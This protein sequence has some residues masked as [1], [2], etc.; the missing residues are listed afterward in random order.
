MSAFHV[1][2]QL[3][4]KNVP[5]EINFMIWSDRMD[6]VALSNVKGEVA[7]HR[8]S[9]TRAWNLSPPKDNLQVNAIA[10]RPDGKVLAV[11]YNSGEVLLISV[12]NKKTLNVKD[13]RTE[14]TCL[15]WVQEKVELKSNDSLNLKE[16]QPKDYMKYIDLT[17]LYL[18]D[19]PMNGSSDSSTPGDTKET[20]FL[21]EQTELNLLLVGTKDGYLHI[22]VFGCFTCSILNINDYL[23]SACSIEDI[24]ISEDLSKIFVTVKDAQ[25]N[26]K[27][28][29]IN[30]QIFK[31]HVQELFC[32]AIK[33]VKLVDLV[34]YLTNTITNIT[35]TWE[36][37][38]LEF[39]HK[40]SKYAKK[41]PEGGI[42]ADFLDFLM[43]GICAP[44]L[45]E[46]LMTDLT[47]KGLEKFGQ[48][49]EMS[50]SNIQKLL[51]NNI[52][53]FGQ[54][55][56]YHLAE[57]RGMARFE[58]RYGI[59]GINEDQINNA[60]Q[61]TGAFLIKAGE[62]QQVINHSVI[63]YKAFFRWLYG[64]ILYLTD[65]AVSSEIH[66]TAEQDLTYI[67]EFLQNFDQIG[68]KGKEG[69]TTNGF[70]ME[71]VGQYLADAPLK[72]TSDLDGNEWQNFLSKNECLR[73]HAHILQHYKSTSLIQQFKELAVNISDIFDTPKM[74]LQSEFKAS[75]VFDFFDFNAEPLKMSS[76]NVTKE[77]MLFSFIEPS[78]NIYLL[79]VHVTDDKCLAR[80]G[81][82][83]FTQ[84]TEDNSQVYDIL[85]IAF[86]SNNILSVLLQENS[87]YKL[88]VLL[89]FS[90]PSA[91]DNLVEI[92]IHSKINRQTLPNSDGSL[93]SP[94]LIK[95]VEMSA[96]RFAVSGARR[97]S[98][99]LSENKRK[100]KLF[101]MEAEEEDE[102]DADMT[103]NTSK[104]E[105]RQD[106]SSNDVSL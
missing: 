66:K 79:Q 3:E 22:R 78:T 71:R 55:L 63:N 15:K 42:T 38:L 27:I 29:V 52:T 36:S 61:S 12:E 98:I 83:H 5:N 47:K 84:S 77:M 45:E 30:A 95:N 10:W 85:D 43:F 106:R 11:G 31:T 103:C 54:N 81:K 49:I 51:L 60:I 70:V 18:K 102:E 44:E 35:E 86:Y 32:I 87:P 16:E 91:L 96:S 8:L 93:I 4:D 19:P 65:E 33:Y 90:L 26:I 40:L 6:L 64:V 59:T 62:M 69:Q 67:T 80:Y 73:N 105:S 100:V 97:V 99:V 34:K 58:H 13:A 21:Q 57:L 41:V 56:S 39:D 14:I 24:H 7:L 75:Y 76:I 101:E 20:N 23:G 48:T 2:K 50:Y 25:N 9:W 72:I 46:F 37:F 104:D 28:V 53:K 92:D 1:I 88:A 89:Q 17:K 68:N 94:K 74:K 82:F